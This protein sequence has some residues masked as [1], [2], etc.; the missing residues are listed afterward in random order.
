MIGVQEYERLEESDRWLQCLDE[1][2]VDNWGGIEEAHRIKREWD[3][4]G[5]DE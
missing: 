1:A 2:G 5:D 3:A 4:E